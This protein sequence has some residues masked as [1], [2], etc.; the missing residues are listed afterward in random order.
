M[1]MNAQKMFTR[2]RGGVGGTNHDGTF[3]L[4]E[5]VRKLGQRQINGWQACADA[6]NQYAADEVRRSNKGLKD[7]IENLR[8]FQR[9]V[10]AEKQRIKTELEDRVAELERCQA[11]NTSAVKDHS[12]RIATM[13]GTA[14]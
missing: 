7:E 1:T 6:A 13:Q 12:E 4:P 8:A 11:L 14:E 3:T 10:I 2:Y 5:D 9:A